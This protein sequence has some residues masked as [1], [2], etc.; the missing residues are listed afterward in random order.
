[1]VLWFYCNSYIHTFVW[2]SIIIRPLEQVQKIPDI[3]SV[4]DNILPY[5]VEK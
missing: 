4:T 5:V 2:N 3:Q 1:M